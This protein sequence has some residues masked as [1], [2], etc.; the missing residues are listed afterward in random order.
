MLAAA[1]PGN[2][3]DLDLTTVVTGG[4][5]PYVY[6]APATT[7]ATVAGGVLV[8]NVLTVTSA[9]AGAAVIT[10]NVTDANGAAV[11]VAVNVT[12]NTELN[13]AAGI[14]D[15][16]QQVG[17]AATDIDLT[18]V[19]GGGTG[20]LAFVAVSADE[21]AVVVE[22]TG[23]TLSVTALTA[24]MAGTPVTVTVT[25]T[26]DFGSINDTFDVTRQPLWGDGS[27]NGEVTA[28]DA[29][30]ALQ[31]A[32]GLITVQAVP[33]TAMQIWVL[34]VTG[35]GAVT[36]FDGAKILQFSAGIITC[37]TV[38]V[39]C[40][41][42]TDVF[43][44]GQMG[45]G[46]VS[47]EPTT[48]T[49]TLPVAITGDVNDVYSMQ[50]V[51]QIDM[52]S[53]TFK[54]VNADLPEG[55]QVIHNLTDEGLLSVAM[56]GTT[57]INDPGE[58]VNLMFELLDETAQPTFTAD[59]MVNENAS[60]SFG[61]VTAREIPTEFALHGNYPNPFNPTTNIKYSLP[62]GAH[63]VLEVFDVTGR[64]VQKLVD[65][66]VEAGHHMV[67]WDARNAV[68][69]QV[70]SGLYIYRIHAADFV[71]VKTMLLVK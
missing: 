52:E 3:W 56:A 43:A 29:T 35:N 25:V 68:G 61:E 17:A 31:E 71:D 22:I 23:T 65:G 36:A 32:A 53:V 41:A 57:P 7:D 15:F 12:V 6:G 51:S 46:E 26:D 39:G 10:V 28:F 18:G 30:Y 8:G 40:P 1:A 64:L 42:K 2:T 33:L 9:G 13:V 50:F 14:A 47:V 63:V 67:R 24:D 37:F 54:A 21:T 59:G 66:E 27:V 19:F 70:A 62:E 60:V 11:V 38:E 34:D 20:T 48:K 45:W 5:T 16:T 49:V 69:V 55:W 58:Y 4:A 44:T